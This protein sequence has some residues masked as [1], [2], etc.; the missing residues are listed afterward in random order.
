MNGGLSE[1]IYNIVGDRPALIVPGFTLKHGTDC[2]PEKN[3]T[4]RYY[5]PIMIDGEGAHFKH[6]ASF[7]HLRATADPD[8]YVWSLQT[9]IMA[10]ELKSMG[11]VTVNVDRDATP[12][13]YNKVVFAAAKAMLGK[14][15]K[16]QSQ[17]LDTYVRTGRYVDLEFAHY[18]Q[19]AHKKL[20]E[21]KKSQRGRGGGENLVGGEAADVAEQQRQADEE[22]QQYIQRRARRIN[23][24]RAQYAMG[25]LM[26][27][28][29]SGSF[30]FNSFEENNPDQERIDALDWD[31]E[32]ERGRITLEEVDQDAEIN[33]LFGGVA[34][35]EEEENE[36]Q[37][38]AAATDTGGSGDEH[39]FVPF[40]EEEKV[41]EKVKFTVTPI[42]REGGDPNVHEDIIGYLVGFIVKDSTWDPGKAFDNILRYNA[43]QRTQNKGGNA[44]SRRNVNHQKELDTWINNYMKLFSSN[45]PAGKHTDIDTYLKVVS[46]IN[47]DLKIDGY[48]KMARTVNH[49]VKENPGHFSNVLTLKMAL[50]KLRDGGGDPY[51]LN[52][53]DWD[54]DTREAK[55]HPE[56]KTYKY[57][58]QQVFWTHP[59]NCGLSEQYFP[60]VN[61]DDNFRRLLLNG[62]DITKFIQE[63][64]AELEQSELNDQELGRIMTPI[65]RYICDTPVVRRRVVTEGLLTYRTNNEF[66]HRAAEAKVIAKTVSKYYPDHYLKTLKRVQWYVSEYGNGWRDLL[67]SSFED[68]EDSDLVDKI[69]ECERFNSVRQK[70]S[71]ACMRIFESLWQLGGNTDNIPIPE[72]IKKMLIWYQEQKEAG[73]LPNLTRDFVN[74][75]PELTTFGNSILR[76][77]LYYGRIAKIIQPLICVLSEGLFSVYDGLERTLA[78]H[79]TLHGRYDV[80]KTFT[81]ITTLCNFTCISGTVKEE[82][83]SSAQADTSENHVYDWILAADEMMHWEVSEREAAKVPDL[84]NKAKIKYTRNQVGRSVLTY[85]PLPNGENLR[86]RKEIVTDQYFTKVSTTNHTVEEKGA[87]AS[88]T[89]TITVKQTNIP[90][91]ELSTDIPALLKGDAKTYFQINQF[92]S[93][94][95][96]KAIMCGAIPSVNMTLFNNISNRVLAY[97]R[98]SGAIT[99]EDGQRGLEIMRP[100]ARQMVVKRAIHEVF[101]KPGGPCYKKEFHTSMIGELAP[102]LYCTTDIV[103]FVWT[104]LASQWVNGDYFNVLKAATKLAL[105]RAGIGGTWSEV[106]TP[107]GFYERDAKNKY[108]VM[109]WKESK[110]QAAV[111]SRPM[112]VGGVGGN[113]NGAEQIDTSCSEA[114]RKLVDINY[115]TL[116]GTKGQLA[117]QI[118]QYTNGMS[119]ND[120]RGVLDQ[121]AAKSFPMGNKAFTPQPKGTFAKWHKFETM[122]NDDT[123]APGL[124]GTGITMMT[125]PYME[126]NPDSDMERTEE[127]VPRMADNIALPVI[128]M[129]DMDRK[130]LYFM[131]MAAFKYRESIIKDALYHATMCESTPVGKYML[132]TPYA[133]DPSFFQV[134]SVDEYGKEKMI[135]NWDRIIGYTRDANGINHY[136]DPTIPES[137]RAVSRRDGIVFT[138]RAA[139]THKESKLLSA[140]SGAPVEEGDTRWIERYANALRSVQNASEIWENLDDHSAMLRHAECGRPLDEPV[141]TQTWIARQERVVRRELGMKLH[142]DEDYPFSVK[143]V[144]NNDMNQANHQRYRKSAHVS[145]DELTKYNSEALSAF[146]G[147]LTRE[148]KRQRR[149]QLRQQQQQQQ[150]STTNQQ[151]QRRGRNRGN[152]MRP[153]NKRR[154]ESSNGVDLDNLP[155]QRTRG[156]RRGSSSPPRISIPRIPDILSGNTNNSNARARAE[157]IRKQRKRKRKR[158]ESNTNVPN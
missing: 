138:Q 27:Q 37:P 82:S 128:D 18:V 15:D 119:A 155:L 150:P 34:V 8:P 134:A 100:L 17:L 121:L 21:K 153:T 78:F 70:A 14:A 90:S 120:V 92:L 41:V 30:S 111:Q 7:G 132:G 44:R 56:L 35:E 3:V 154:G 39:N 32:I 99:Y 2:E 28:L 48:I 24:H 72:T 42:P 53:H 74:Y 43:T 64:G 1:N 105:A 147:E 79:L 107:Y 16:Q 94:C 52:Q 95:T 29:G 114:D 91:N 9:M 118:A 62:D 63:T 149:E 139:I 47:P 12:D 69:R 108:G 123:G 61:M 125:S 93:A 135:R 87:L 136:D 141:R 38:A 66:M 146:T 71:E 31:A 6:A 55:F 88:R 25:R 19:Q 65:Q 89:A 86:Y 157:K 4:S 101:D 102:Y 144:R 152:V 129:S 60:D 127:D 75:D 36:A 109:P 57:M 116:K 131:P 113:A 103:W 126:K 143:K 122:P 51:Y 22:R 59:D 23:R 97:L 85:L 115:L 142:L 81:A 11:G 83:S 104:A 117:G 46:T 68:H 98:K 156:E 10:V 106:D 73:K 13:L 112:G 67:P 58:G 96:K 137:E 133:D 140:A 20:A 148:Q 77:L 50:D 80:G 130:Y 40:D 49:M 54:G 151:R 26:N 76:S 33:E 84:A 45:H 5:I 158:Q 124:K 110:N 145:N